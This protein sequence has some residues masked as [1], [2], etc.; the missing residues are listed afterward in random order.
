VFSTKKR[1]PF[2]S[3][4]L[5]AELYSYMAGICRAQGTQAIQIGGVE[6]HVHLLF[7]LPRTIM[8]S[9]LVEEIKKSSS[10]W[11]KTKGHPRFSWQNGYGAFSVS[12]SHKD[13]VVSYI[14][15]QREHHKKVSFQEEYRRLLCKNQIVFDERYVWD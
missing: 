1:E 2:I 4:T 3:Q 6:D 14:L 12:C 13:A 9:K 15:G 11:F 10:R 8:I 5:E 7:N